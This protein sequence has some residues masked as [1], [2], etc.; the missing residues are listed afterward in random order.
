MGRENSSKE[1]IAYMAVSEISMKYLKAPTTAKPT[2]GLL[3]NTTIVAIVI[4]IL[5][6][7]FLA[8]LGLYAF[9]RFRR[10]SY[11][12]SFDNKHRAKME[13]ELKDFSVD[14]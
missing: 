9:I 3:S 2:A 10:P 14:F 4:G 7:I 13:I 1:N 11:N 5:A 6:L 8:T 12:K